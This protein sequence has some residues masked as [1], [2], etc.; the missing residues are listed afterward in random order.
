VTL[1]TLVTSPAV[2][3]VT[4][5]TS[6][7]TLGFDDVLSPLAWHSVTTETDLVRNQPPEFRRTDRSRSMTTIPFAERLSC[8]IEE[9]RQATGLGRTKLYEM[10][11]AGQ[12]ETF[13]VGKRRLI[14]VASLLKLAG[15]KPRGRKTQG[16]AK[17]DALTL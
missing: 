11:D 7:E 1:V 2:V 5:V 16:G 9:A 15:V 12:V 6:A 4:T 3:I 10:M 17:L 8:T 14:L 13:H